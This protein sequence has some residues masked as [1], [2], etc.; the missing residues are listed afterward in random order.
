MRA[1]LQQLHA[2]DEAVTAERRIRG[3]TTLYRLMKKFGIEGE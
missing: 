1:R 3:R 2:L